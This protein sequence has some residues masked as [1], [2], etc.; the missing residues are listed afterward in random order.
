MKK[1]AIQI[2]R[3]IKKIQM[4]MNAIQKRVVGSRKK[5]KKKKRLKMMIMLF[6]LKLADVTKKMEIKVGKL[7]RE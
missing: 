3:N 2:I 1:N 4:T 5:E 6:I 7:W